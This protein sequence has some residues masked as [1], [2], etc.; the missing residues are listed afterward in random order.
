VCL[1]KNVMIRLWLD[2]LNSLVVILFQLIRIGF[3]K[4][5][6][7]YLK[8]RLGYLKLG[9]GLIMSSYQFR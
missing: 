8:L 3:F 6:L 4:L 7:V 9:L 2:R 5:V 1:K